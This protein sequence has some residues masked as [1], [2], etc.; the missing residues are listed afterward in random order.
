[1]PRV[2]VVVLTLNEAE[3]IEA[4][5]R[6]AIESGF[7]VVVL[8]GGSGDETVG[9]A[10]AAGCSVKHRAFDDFAS[11]RNWI[12]ER[13]D[14]EYAFFVDA[15]E[16]IT[17]PLALEVKRLAAQG[18]DAAWVP[19]LDYFA[20]RW[21]TAGG[22]YPQPHLRLLRPGSARFG[23]SVHEVPT[24]GKDAVVG[25]C[26]QPLLHMSHVTVGHFLRKLDAYT[27]M[28][29][30]ELRGKPALLLGR[31]VAEACAVLVR[32]LLVQRGWRDGRHGVIGAILHAVY[33]FVLYSKA[34]TRQP[35]DDASS[36]QALEVLMRARRLRRRRGG[37][38]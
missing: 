33:R 5:V 11:Q 1:M 36:S 4:C 13:V 26:E 30:A 34:A 18:V 31:G 37:A 27:E 19:T 12:L 16:V 21:M 6:A 38:R 20:G 22:W 29:A 25:S 3:R 23:R 2:V 14:A 28:E 9:L 7:E 17:P 35:H 10:L 24:L 32:R 15:D 8:D